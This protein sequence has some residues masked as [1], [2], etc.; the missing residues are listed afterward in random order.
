MIEFFDVVA[1]LIGYTILFIVVGVAII[2]AVFKMRFQ[3]NVS[4]EAKQMAKELDPN[5][6]IAGAAS[7]VMFQGLL[8][9]V[10]E[11]N[12]GETIQADPDPLV[13]FDWSV[14]VGTQED[15]EH[16]MT[17]LRNAGYHTHPLPEIETWRDEGRW[18]TEMAGVWH[19][20]PTWR[21]VEF[22]DDGSKELKE[23]V[24]LPLPDEWTQ[25]EG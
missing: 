15:I 12:R 14:D 18:S 20:T 8:D 17:V 4:P 23:Q 5:N 10:R 7:G 3:S 9:S 19:E 22:H 25:P 11:L 13:H 21:I 24:D 1:Q 2:S 6:P 16:V